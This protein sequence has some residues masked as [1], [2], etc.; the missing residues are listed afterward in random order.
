MEKCALFRK[1]R[2][3]LKQK[4]KKKE[5][6]G[7]GKCWE[8]HQTQFFQEKPTCRNSPKLLCYSQGCVGCSP[9]DGYWVAKQEN[10]SRHCTSFI[11]STGKKPLLQVNFHTTH[12]ALLGVEG[13]RKLRR[14]LFPHCTG[15]R[16]TDHIS[17]WIVV[18][19]KQKKKNQGFHYCKCEWPLR[20]EGGEER[21]PVERQQF[22]LRIC[23]ISSF[24]GAVL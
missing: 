3:A 14:L 8:R 15:T 16:I 12:T 4:K 18:G 11:Q 21:K 24:W 13:V 7:S 20:M 17:I 23:G 10:R 5:V 19:K 9:P 2:C 6:T 1:R 22:L